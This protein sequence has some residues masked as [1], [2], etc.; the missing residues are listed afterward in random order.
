MLIFRL[1]NIT[2]C[3]GEL[4][5]RGHVLGTI[6]NL[7]VLFPIPMLPFVARLHNRIYLH[8]ERTKWR[9]LVVMLIAGRFSF[10]YPSRN[11]GLVGSV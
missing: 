4:V 7:P 10:L 5:I 2:C 11:D 6:H 1:S 9:I 3:F 8:E